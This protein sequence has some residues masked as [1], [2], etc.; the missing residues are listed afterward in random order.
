VPPTSR[1]Y[2]EA[3]TRRAG[4]LATSNGGLPA[5]AAAMKSIEGVRLDARDRSQLTADVL[6]AA[7]D[8]VLRDGPSPAVR[9]GDHPADEPALRDG[10]E[11]TYRDLATLA[12]TRAEKVALVDAANDVRRWTVR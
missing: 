10:L 11:R 12:A 1:A 2:T 3:R 4:L 9:I 6:R 7:L 8:Q 5:L